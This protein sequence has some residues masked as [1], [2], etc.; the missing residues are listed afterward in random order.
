[1]AAIGRHSS[2]GFHLSPAYQKP[3]NPSGLG[4]QKPFNLSWFK[5]RLKWME[6][7]ILN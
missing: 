7:A 2:P 4:V 6:I 1:M 5:Y 3:D